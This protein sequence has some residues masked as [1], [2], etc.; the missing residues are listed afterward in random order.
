MF[1]TLATVRR[2][3]VA[4]DRLWSAVAGRSGRGPSG[5]GVCGDW[6]C[7]LRSTVPPGEWPQQSVSRRVAP[8]L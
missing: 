2:H 4:C 8:Q 7:T 6:F 1:S 3:Q 5:A